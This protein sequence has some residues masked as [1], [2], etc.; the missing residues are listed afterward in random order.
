MVQHKAP[1]IRHRRMQG[2][3]LEQLSRLSITNMYHELEL[4][5]FHEL[6]LSRLS[7]TKMCPLPALPPTIFLT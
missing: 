6:E 1:Y 7:I 2:A 5:L 3:K 4:S